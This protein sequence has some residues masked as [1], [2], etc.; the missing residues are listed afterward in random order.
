MLFS[1]VATS[2]SLLGVA[3]LTAALKSLLGLGAVLTTTS[4]SGWREVRRRVGRSGFGRKE[5][6]GIP[7]LLVGRG[8]LRGDVGRRGGGHRIITCS[9]YLLI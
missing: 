9:V 7:P 4:S 6:K 5:S 1:A 3:T 2:T 8:S